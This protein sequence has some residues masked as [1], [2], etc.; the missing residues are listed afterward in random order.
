MVWRRAIG[1]GFSGI[2]V[3][4]DRLYTM[5]SDGT[6]EYVVAL[7]AGTGKEVW[8]V[9]AGP[10]LLDSMGNGPRTTPILDADRVYAMGSHGRLLALNAADGAEVWRS[11]SPRRSVPSGPTGG[12]RDR[13]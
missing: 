8:R 1:E 6:T 11:R 3:V 9:P 4:G 10:K 2:S 5:D 13:R 12:T 7:E